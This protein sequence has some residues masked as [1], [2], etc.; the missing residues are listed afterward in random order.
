MIVISDIFIKPFM[1]RD[2]HNIHYP[3]HSLIHYS[4]ESEI[5]DTINLNNI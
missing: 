2:I 5:L 3:L 4:K 1:W